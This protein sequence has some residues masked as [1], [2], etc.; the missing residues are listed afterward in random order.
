MRIFHEFKLMD[1][2]RESL[3]DGSKV[4]IN[5]VELIHPVQILLY[6]LKRS[7]TKSIKKI[8]DGWRKVQ[9]PFKDIAKFSEWVH[10]ISLNMLVCINICYNS[11]NNKHYA[12]DWYKQNV[13]FRYAYWSRVGSLFLVTVDCG[14]IYFLAVGKIN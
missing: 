13:S 8:D 9:L 11:I 6:Q 14:F 2:A 10:K 1:K 5:I 7:S 3:V 4:G 12:K